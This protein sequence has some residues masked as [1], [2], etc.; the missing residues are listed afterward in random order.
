MAAFDLVRFRGVAFG[1]G[2]PDHPLQDEEAVRDA[3]AG[4]AADP[5]AALAELTGWAASINTTA[6]FSPGRRARVAMLLDDAARARWRALGERYLAPGGRPSEGRDG[7]PAILRALFDS[8]SEFANSY[9]TAIDESRE[10]PGWVVE[11]LPQVALRNM[12]WL[13]RRLALAHM[14]RLPVTGAVWER[15]HRLYGIARE[16]GVERT[17]LPVFAGDKVMSSVNQEYVR[18]LLLEI[19]DP[20]ALS[21]RDIELVFRITARKATHVR[22]EP[23]PLAGAVYAVLPWRDSR[24]VTVASLGKPHADA[25][26]IDTSSCLPPLRTLLDRDADADAA[27]RDTLYGPEYTVRERRAMLRRLLDLWGPQPPQRR[28]RRVRLASPARVLSG[29]EQIAKLVPALEPEV[30]KRARPARTPLRLQ[31]DNTGNDQNRRTRSAAARLENAR[32]ID[33]STGGLGIAVSAPQLPWARIGTLVGVYVEPGPDWVVGVLRRIYAVD[34]E[35]RLGVQV[36]AHRPRLV[37]LRGRQA[38]RAGAWEEERRLEHDF[39]ELFQRA[40]LTESAGVPL[41]AGALLLP[42]RLARRGDQYDVPLADGDQP[43][44]VTAVLE[45]GESYQ[46][47]TFEAAG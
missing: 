13:A 20:R 37:R 34:R 10:R 16:A 39:D 1:G 29:F 23:A 36:L 11:N 6:G 32:L 3:L 9:G 43:I 40:L 18:L 45:D 41:R 25:L 4:L 35:L 19:A 31:L 24:P 44:R 22:L 27:D 8:A 5:A 46:R 15:L 14:L 38:G 28:K 30:E 7:E 47:V 2:L 21:G 42:P 33:A 12:R 17:M 26:Y